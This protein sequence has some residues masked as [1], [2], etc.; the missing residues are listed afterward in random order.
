M[1]EQLNLFE[2]DLTKETNAESLPTN[3]RTNERTN[4]HRDWIGNM[5]AIYSTLGASSHSNYEREERDFYATDPKA[6]EILFRDGQIELSQNILEPSAGNGHLAVVLKEHGF[7]VTCR[8]IVQRDYPLD[9]VGDFLETSEMWD[10][11]IVMNP[12]YKYALEHIK[13]ALE[14]IPD[15]HKVVAF[16]KLQFLEGKARRVFYET[17]QLKT[18]Y[19]ASGRLICANNGH[20]EQFKS[21]A[22]CYAWFEWQKGFK[23]DPIIK[24]IN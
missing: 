6:L 11:D 4:E 9:A 7:N 24:W 14:I 10:G 20:F 12:P 1:N 13:K 3:E 17:K 23:G 15:G 5:K 22:V 18:V 21:S 8:D 2:K 19:V 16:L